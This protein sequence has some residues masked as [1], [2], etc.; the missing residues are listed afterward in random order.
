[1]G[2]GIGIGLFFLA[3]GIE[4]GLKG[5]GK[6]MFMAKYMEHNKTAE[7]LKT[8]MKNLEKE[9]KDESKRKSEESY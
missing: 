8:Y 9:D 5:L 3:L 6:W 7:H 2:F 1:M 4:G